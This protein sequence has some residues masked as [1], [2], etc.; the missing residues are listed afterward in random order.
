MASQFSILLAVSQNKLF[1]G[2]NWRGNPS[3]IEGGELEKKGGDYANKG[4]AEPYMI[5]MGIV[6][7]CI[8]MKNA[9]TMWGGRVF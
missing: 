7:I 1:W 4:L 3:S 2:A 5:L 9:N 8:G 6:K